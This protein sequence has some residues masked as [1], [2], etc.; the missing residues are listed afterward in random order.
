[1]ETA[2]ELPFVG[3][4]V[5]STDYPKDGLDMPHRVTYDY[6]PSRL[7]QDNTSSQEL[8]CYL[9]DK[10]GEGM[11]GLLWLQ[12]TSPFRTVEDV[13]KAFD[14]WKGE[15]RVVSGGMNDKHDVTSLP[16]GAIYIIPPD[17]IELKDWTK[18]A[19]ILFMPEKRSL[20]I[21]TPEDWNKAISWL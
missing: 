21:D 5:L 3:R 2:L 20:D 11:D 19:K 4:V 8:A 12:P 9:W 14:F 15:G 7:A 18:D 16:N 17:E 1:M 13:K 6:R 10:F